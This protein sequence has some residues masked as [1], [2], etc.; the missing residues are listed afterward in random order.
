MSNAVD[1]SDKNGKWFMRWDAESSSSFGGRFTRLAQKETTSP[2]AFLQ[3]TCLR[4]TT[5]TSGVDPETIY[6]SKATNMFVKP[7]IWTFKS[8][9]SISTLWAL[10][11]S[12]VAMYSHKTSRLICHLN[13]MSLAKSNLWISIWRVP[14]TRKV[15][16]LQKPTWETLS[17]E[18]PKKLMIVGVA[19]RSSQS[20]D[21]KPSRLVE[22]TVYILQPLLECQ[23][24]SVDNGPWP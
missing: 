7:I 17:R 24:Y 9:N 8:H 23:Q 16:F 4:V 15:A 5:G 18:S 19:C 11:I 10:T 3:N 2:K 21:K 22:M 20:L 13:L 6:T 1:S 14:S 12:T